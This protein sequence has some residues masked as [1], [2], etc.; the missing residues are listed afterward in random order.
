MHLG[1]ISGVPE[2]GASNTVRDSR[3][4]QTIPSS[5]SGLIFIR[6]WHRAKLYSKTNNLNRHTAYDP[7]ERSLDSRDPT[8]LYHGQALTERDLDEWSSFDSLSRRSFQRLQKRL[9][10]DKDVPMGLFD[11]TDHGSIGTHGL[12]SCIGL[13]VVGTG[14]CKGKLIAHIS[15]AT[16][17]VQLQRLEPAISDHPGLQKPVVYVRVRDSAGPHSPT[18]EARTDM[19]GAVQAMLRRLSINARVHRVPAG[20]T[21]LS[22]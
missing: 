22:G 13:V 18:T 15:P 2:P 3:R 12:E 5:V 1:I 10:W 4:R 6:C 7:S 8:S 17:Q 16:H 14:A 20:G 21:G 9:P 19:A 11:Y